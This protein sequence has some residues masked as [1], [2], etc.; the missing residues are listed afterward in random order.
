MIE[1]RSS[2]RGRVPQLW[3]CRAEATPDLLALPGC[4]G[5]T[6]AR[7]TSPDTKGCIRGGRGRCSPSPHHT[8]TAHGSQGNEACRDRGTDQLV[9]FRP[10]HAHNSRDPFW[11]HHHP[12]WSWGGEAVGGRSFRPTAPHPTWHLLEVLKT[13]TGLLQSP[14]VCLG[15][16]DTT[17]VYGKRVSGP[18]ESFF[19]LIITYF[20][21]TFGEIYAAP[22]S[23]V[24][25][26]LL[27]KK[28]P[29]GGKPCSKLPFGILSPEPSLAPGT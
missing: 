10:P 17:C 23:C 5:C 3:G 19:I 13:R 9:K 25:Q 6:W 29:K 12:R 7:S 22:E 26:I 1:Q 8:R 15:D 27:H 2:D 21:Y 11:Q 18:S 24:S 16:P 28:R 14:G 20:L 4:S